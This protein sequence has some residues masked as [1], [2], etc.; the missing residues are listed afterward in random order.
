MHNPQGT[1]VW[2]ELLSND[3][4]AAARFYADVIGWKVQEPAPDDPHGYYHF[5]AP[6]GFV[7]GMMQLS[8]DMRA[9]GAKP[10]WLSYLGVDDVDATVARITEAGGRVLMPAMET[11]KV[12]R[13]AMIADPQGNPIYVMRG[14]SDEPSTAYERN[15]LGKCGWNE[16]TTPDHAAGNAFYASIF[17]WQYPD[18]MDMPGG[19]SYTF[20]AVGGQVIGA[21]MPVMPDSPAGWCFYFRV[22]DLDAAIARVRA[23]GGSCTDPMEVPGGEKISIVTDPEGVTFGIVAGQGAAM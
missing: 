14:A 16:L 2:Y 8:A 7:G 19:A 1:P 18:K 17:G 5:E 4:P 20:V 6:G 21:T 3:A 10:T 15:G 11:P 23:G 22:A 13:F 9:H 12:G